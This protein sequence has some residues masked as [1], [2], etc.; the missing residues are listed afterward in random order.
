MSNQGTNQTNVTKETR[1]HQA[2]AQP[3]ERTSKPEGLKEE[4]VR[5]IAAGSAGVP[6]NR[7]G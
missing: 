2:P 4:V 5:A 3:T 6:G 7:R 1:T